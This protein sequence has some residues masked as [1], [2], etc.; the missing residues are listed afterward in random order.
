MALA[1]LIKL[2]PL[3]KSIIEKSS[4]CFHSAAHLEVISLIGRE[5]PSILPIRKSWRKVELSKRCIGIT[6]GYLIFYERVGFLRLCSSG[7]EIAFK[8]FLSSHGNISTELWLSLVMVDEDLFEGHLHRTCLLF[9]DLQRRRRDLKW[10]S[11]IYCV[12]CRC[13]GY[14]RIKRERR[15]W[16]TVRSKKVETEMTQVAMMK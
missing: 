5:S 11:H 7:F 1:N 3:P 16:M 4:Q 8:L 9:H 13:N 2:Y 15:E 14:I 10:E 6:I 12:N